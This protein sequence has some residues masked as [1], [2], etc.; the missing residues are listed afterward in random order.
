MSLIEWLATL[1]GLACVWLYVRQSIWSWPTGLVQVVLF[2][3]VFF[4]AR[5]YSD[6]LLHLVY[7][8]LQLYGWY[9]WW[10]GGGGPDWRHV[11]PI[12]RLRASEG[13]LWLAVA[14]AGAVALGWTMRR[15]TNADLPYPDAAIAV[16][17]L[18]AQYLIARKVLENWPLWIA[19]DVLAIAVYAYKGLYVTT[20]LYVVFLVMAN[21]G[22]F[23]WTRSYREQ[24]P[25]GTSEPAA[26]SS[27]A[28]SSL[29][30][31]GISS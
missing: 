15:F 2:A 14:G 13:A 29:P 4:H 22:W 9:H 28:S 31:A 3:W 1:F 6:F 11:L 19:V 26:D 7:I 27:S 18:I 25:A 10:R 30:T 5:L 8:V 17:S 21:V 20:G 24:G 12:T 16:M 23:Q